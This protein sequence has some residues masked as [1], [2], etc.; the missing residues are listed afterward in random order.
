MLLLY[1]DG[2]ARETSARYAAELAR[3]LEGQLVVLMLTG[4]E[5][6]ET[7]IDVKQS[8]DSTLQLITELGVAA[9]GAWRRGDKASEFIKFLAQSPRF[10]TMVWGGREAVMEGSHSGRS[11]HWLNRVGGEANCPIVTPYG[12]RQP[13]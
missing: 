3:R 8:L 6:V 7:G 11:A 2:D 5:R 10:S 12:R 1:E 9:R 4:P 13:R